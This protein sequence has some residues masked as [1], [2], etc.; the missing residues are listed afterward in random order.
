MSIRRLFL[1][2]FVVFVFIGTVNAQEN[3]YQIDALVHPNCKTV[4]ITVGGENADIYGFTSSAITQAVNIVKNKHGGIVKLNPGIFGISGP[5]ILAS[6]VTLTGAGAQTVLKKINGVRTPFIIDADY[7]E[8]KVTVKDPTGFLSGMGVQLYDK[9]QNSG[10]DVSTALI[11][12]IEQNTIYIDNYLARDYVADA[13]GTLS[14]ACSIISAVGTANVRIENLV[15]DGNKQTN[16]FLNG[17]RGGAVYVHKSTNTWIENIEVRDF[18]G[19]GI[20]WQLTE[21]VTVRN[22]E[23]SGCT[24]SGLHPGTGSPKS[25]IEGNNSHHNGNEGIFI[26]WRVHHGIVRN[27]QFHHNGRHGI[28]TGHKDT[29]MYFEDNHVF[30]NG[31]DGINFRYEKAANAPHR[32]TFVRN[33]IEDNGTKNGGYG[34]SIVFRTNVLR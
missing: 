22:C 15:V 21:N 12:K 7:G 10:W 4:T 20:S 29:D 8:L 32:N 5:V 27:N 26:C 25:T 13:E 2:S 11:T 6:N 34:F 18:N 30:Q 31:N 14:N 19:D 3:N 33:T 16:D 17:C 28:C 24:N 1:I 23:V 9:N